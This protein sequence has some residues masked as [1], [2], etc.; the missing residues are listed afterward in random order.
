[1]RRSK[2]AE[3][4]NGYDMEYTQKLYREREREKKSLMKVGLSWSH[5]ALDRIFVTRF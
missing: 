2:H 4:D 1:M 5:V 3:N